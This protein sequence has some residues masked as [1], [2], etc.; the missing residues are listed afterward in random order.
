MLFFIQQQVKL[1]E[2]NLHKNGGAAEP[3][4]NPLWSAAKRPQQQ[5]VVQCD[6]P[7]NPQTDSFLSSQPL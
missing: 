6:Q 7:A 3:P 1:M 2:K 4:T 5:R